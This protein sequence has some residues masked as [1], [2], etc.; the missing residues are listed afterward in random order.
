VTVTDEA[1]V[2]AGG[3]G[4]RLRG[5]VDD[6]PKSLAPV[7]GKPFL[8]WLLDALAAQGLHHVVLATGYRG[9]QIEAALGQTWRG[10]MLDY[11]REP[12][13]LG[14][15]GAVALALQRVDGEACLVLNGDTWLGLDYARFDAAV[16]AMDAR[17]GVALAAV[18]DVSRYGAVRVADGRI[19][20]FA[21]KDQTGPGLVNAGVYR[22]SRSLLDGFPTGKAFSFERDVLVPAVAGEAVAGYVETEGFIDIGVPEDYRRVQTLFAARAVGAG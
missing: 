4:T 11:S 17:L 13:P 18:P 6:V 19:T 2:L 12:E 16:C 3:L 7:A 8:A 22:F 10:M 20:G 1:I 5:V 15:G 14:T 9:D 21:E